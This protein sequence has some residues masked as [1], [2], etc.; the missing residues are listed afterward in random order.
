MLLDS[1][2]ET[3]PAHYVS[4]GMPPPTTTLE[5]LQVINEMHMVCDHFPGVEKMMFYADVVPWNHNVG[6]GIS[7]ANLKNCRQFYLAFPDMEKKLH[8]V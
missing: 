1:W 4:R 7:V 2:R 3:Q 6:S 8:T 5:H